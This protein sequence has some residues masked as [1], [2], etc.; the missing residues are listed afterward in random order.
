MV[1]TPLQWPNIRNSGKADIFC[2]RF[3]LIVSG[4]I[5]PMSCSISKDPAT[6]D[7]YVT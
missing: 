1:Y 2:F 3:S 7:A 5:I 4:K 6:S